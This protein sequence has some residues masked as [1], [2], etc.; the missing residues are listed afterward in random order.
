MTP[1]DKEQGMW[2]R[3]QGKLKTTETERVRQ[4]TGPLDNLVVL[5][6]SLALLAVIGAGVLYYFI[7]HVSPA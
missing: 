3:R 7:F 1:A 5:V 2:P 6:V 4:G